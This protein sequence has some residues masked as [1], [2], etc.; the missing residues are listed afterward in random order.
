[1]PNDVKPW[2]VLII[3]QDGS[4]NTSSSRSSRGSEGRW[5]KMFDVHSVIGIC[6]ND[7]AVNGGL[8]WRN[9]TED[10]VRVAMEECCL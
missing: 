8:H 2:V 1:M 7:G 3:R 4:M 5:N 9:V 10:K 6:A